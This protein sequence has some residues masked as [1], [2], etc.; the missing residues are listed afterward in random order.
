MQRKGTI[1]ITFYQHES[2]TICR[3]VFFQCLFFMFRIPIL[4]LI[5]TCNCVFIPLVLIVMKVIN[6]FF[7]VMLAF[8]VF[9]T[10]LCFAV[11]VHICEGKV[12]SQAFFRSADAC[13]Q[14][15]E[16]EKEELPACCK[17]I[18]DEKIAQSSSK[19][20]FK[21]KACCFNYSFEYKLDQSSAP[22]NS[23]VLLFCTDGIMDFDFLKFQ[24]GPELS[25]VLLSFPLL[26]P[27]SFLRQDFQSLYQVYLI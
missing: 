4:T 11:D 10:S 27:P 13:E 1:E 9:A 8:V 20:L 24:I 17:K 14:M 26:K 7:L 6:R 21:K 2:Q 22:Q 5:L 12:Q 18:R 15:A 19:S 23:S 3:V 25:D 16:M